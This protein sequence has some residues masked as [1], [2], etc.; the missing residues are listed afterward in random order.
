MFR[1][2]AVVSVGFVLEPNAW[3]KQKRATTQSLQGRPGAEIGRHY[4]VS[5]HPRQQS[6][7][8][9][10]RL[11]QHLAA[12]LLRL[13]WRRRLRRISR[14]AIGLLPIAIAKRQGL[15]PC[16]SKGLGTIL[17]TV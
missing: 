11:F 7:A 12:L 5:Y 8:L 9:L 16:S 10:S 14:S 6:V 15:L 2:A 17:S 3:G 1:W 4:V 13:A